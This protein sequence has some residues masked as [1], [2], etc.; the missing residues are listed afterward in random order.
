L[1]EIYVVLLAVS[2]IA[3]MMHVQR[4]WGC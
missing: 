3:F 1:V 2:V 4:D